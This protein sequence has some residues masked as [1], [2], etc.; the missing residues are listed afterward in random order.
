MGESSFSVEI[1]DKDGNYRRTL[2]VVMAGAVIYVFAD[3][4]NDRE[5][6]R[7][8]LKAAGFVKWEH[9]NGIY[10]SEVQTIEEAA[11]AFDP[12]AE[13]EVTEEEPKPSTIRETGYTLEDMAAAWSAGRANFKSYGEATG[14]AP[15]F[16][17]WIKER[18]DG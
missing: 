13:P 14:D 1:F 15:D 2:R 11:L 18:N 7:G 9:Q 12:E 8:E 5:L 17:S 16:L 4:D 3:G 6:A 10:N